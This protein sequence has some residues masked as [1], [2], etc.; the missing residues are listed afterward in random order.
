MAAIGDLEESR[1]AAKS[2]LPPLLE[3]PDLRAGQ[4]ELPRLLDRKDCD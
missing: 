4:L 2:R 1:L 3:I